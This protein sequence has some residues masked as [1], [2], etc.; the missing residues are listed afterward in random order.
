MNKRSIINYILTGMMVIAVAVAIIFVLGNVSEKI[1]D[2]LNNNY[3]IMFVE[4][5]KGFSAP[6]YENGLHR[7]DEAFINTLAENNNSIAPNLNSRR[8]VFV[9]GSSVSSNAIDMETARNIYR[10]LVCGNGCYRSNR[11]LINLAEIENLIK[12]DDIVKYEVS[13]STFRN[14]DY[15]ITESIMDKWGKYSVREDLSVKKNPIIFAPVYAINVQLIK[16][17]NVWE[18]CMSLIEQKRHPDRYPEPIGVGN[19]KNYYFNYESVAELCHFDNAYAESVEEDIA[20]LNGK[21]NT[22]VELGPLPDGLSNT[23]YGKILNEYIDNELIPY[24]ETNNYVYRDVRRSFDDSEY[25]DG[26]HLDYEATKKYTRE[27]DEYI[28]GFVAGLK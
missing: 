23:E 2:K 22:I 17:Q 15:T 1:L 5:E 10:T 25:T 13:F 27:L 6:W 24:L 9:L 7:V 20:Y 3:R 19:F 18:L 4:G 26:V 21:Y 11:V 28:D 14:S 16:M 12:S 8:T